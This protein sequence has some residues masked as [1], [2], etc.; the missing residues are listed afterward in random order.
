M[1]SF[2]GLSIAVIAICQFFC[3]NVV[4]GIQVIRQVLFGSCKINCDKLNYLEIKSCIREL[5]FAS[6]IW[7][8]A[9][10]YI[11]T[12]AY[13]YCSENAVFLRDLR[14]ILDAKVRFQN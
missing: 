9:Y 5:N 10:K 6:I 7:T 13:F 2:K 3:E 1:F 12:H 4:C 11:E 8:Q 14:P